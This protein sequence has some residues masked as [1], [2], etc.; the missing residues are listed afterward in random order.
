ME[1]NSPIAM[2]IDNSTQ[3]EKINNTIDTPINV[4][5][6]AALSPLPPLR[7]GGKKTSYVWDHFTHNKDP[8]YPRVICNYCGISY[9]RQNTRSG[10]SNMRAHLESQCKKYPLR[11]NREKQAMLNFTVKRVGGENATPTS[12]LKNHVYK[13]EECRKALA[14][15]IICD[16]LSFRFVEGEGFV[17]YSKILE[18]RFTISSRVTIDRD[19]MQIYGE[20]KAKLKLLLKD[21]HVC[22]TSDAWTLIQNINYMCLTAH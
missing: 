3:T 7:P 17:E 16:E 8:K 20:E 13:Y 6:G 4:D 14:K 21:Q 11:F 22:L 5:Q 10:T 2:D 18:P 15:M 19:C 1:A 9:A 12:L